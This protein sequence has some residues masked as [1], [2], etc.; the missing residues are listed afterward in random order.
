MRHDDNKRIDVFVWDRS[1]GSTRRITN[2]NGDSYLFFEDTAGAISDSGRFI[3]FGSQA[4]DLVPGDK[5]GEPDVFVWD[6][7]T[8]NTRRVPG[9]D[10]RGAVISGNGR[11]IAYTV[12]VGPR[13]ARREGTAFPGR[14][15]WDR[16]TRTTHQAH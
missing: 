1:S 4:S 6:R 3:V 15:P 16:A 8:G 12:E 7:R 5:N 10:S 14:V 11:F 2:G 13:P 9:G